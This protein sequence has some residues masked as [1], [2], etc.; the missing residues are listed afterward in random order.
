ML[1][2]LALAPVSAATTLHD[3]T[4]TDPRWQVDHHVKDVVHSPEGLSF[5]VTG[6]D[7]WLTS[8]AIA[9]PAIPASSSRIVFSFTCA[10]TAIANS[11]QLFYAFGHSPFSEVNS[12]RLS[13]VG[14]PPYTRFTGEIPVSA[15]VHGPCRFRL[16]PPG[17]MAAFT[18]KELKMDFLSP[19]WTYQPTTPPPLIIPATTPLVLEGEGWEL[20][21]DPD[22]F[23]AFRFLSPGHS[24]EGNPSESI[25][26]LDSNGSVQTLALSEMKMTAQP[27]LAPR[28]PFFCTSVQATDA[29]GRHWTIKRFFE[30]RTPKPDSAHSVLDVTTR[31]S[32][33]DAHGKGPVQI[34]H[35]PFLTLFANRY[36]HGRKRQALLAGVEYLDDEPSS[37]QKEIRTSEH[38]RLIPADYRISTPLAIL[39]EGSHWLAAEWTRGPYATVFDTPDRLLRSGGHLLG[40]WAPAVGP[41]RH[42]SELAIYTA[43]PFEGGEFHVTLRIGEGGTVAEAL[44][45]LLPPDRL[46][47]PDTVSP[48]ATL[49]LLARGWLD[50]SIRTNTLVRHAIG[51]SFKYHPTGDAPILMKYLAAQLAKHPQAAPQLIMRLRAVSTQMLATI[52]TQDI[53]HASVSHIHHPSPVLIAGDVKS[54]LAH[55]NASMK[56]LNH[57]L[58]SGKRLWKAPAGGPDLGETLGSDHCNGFTSMSLKALLEDAVWSGDEVEIDKTLA[59]LDKVTEHYHGTVPR[60]AQPWEMPL[61]TPD[62]VASA[63]L[64]RAYTL[65]YLLSS[66]PNHLREARHWA[67]TGLSMVYLSSPLPDSIGPTNPVGNYATCAVMGATH[68]IS[69]NWIGR[70]VQWCGLVYASSLWDLA[71]AEPDSTTAAYWNRIATGITTSGVRQTHTADDP[72]AI[73]CLPDSWNLIQQTRY[74]VPINPGTVQ[75]NYTECLGMP[76]YALRSLGRGRLLHA[77]GQ[78]TV[79]PSQGTSLRCRV[80]GW[81]EEPFRIVVTRLEPPR[82]V[83]FNGAP[84]QHEHLSRQRAL[85]ITLPARATGELAIQP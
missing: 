27:A 56:S 39:T 2:C 82:S 35:L 46:P 71:R 44:E 14:G 4:K 51:S 23:G 77:P 64:T 29:D 22:R 32:I 26:Y 5:T 62:I 16:D 68:W 28:S 52:R 63:N 84:A 74:A 57:Q 40:F 25:A 42:E 60:G 1:F 3:F 81:P 54:F 80:S 41:C 31:I 19:I 24:V 75:E 36:D 76:Y 53:P 67:Y 65:G 9:L 10:P 30:R 17:R 66:N 33:N 50:S 18:V 37:N 38:N 8:P 69:P 7:P 20:R 79:L 72:Q 70:P 55:K 15:L 47:P 13:P 59:I 34:L 48:V 45:T 21:H 12:V 73:G 58:A 43:Y 49:E 11:W 83:M 85:L 61:H 78:I 6:D